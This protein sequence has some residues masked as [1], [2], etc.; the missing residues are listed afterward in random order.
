VSKVGHNTVYQLPIYDAPL[1]RN[2]LSD[3]ARASLD[4][5]IRAL[6]EELDGFDDKTRQSTMERRLNRFD[7]LRSR[8]ALFAGVLSFKADDL[9]KKLEQA[10]R[11]LR[12]MLGLEAPPALE[13]M[14]EELPVA[15]AAKEA[16]AWTPEEAIGF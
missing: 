3:V 11:D 12:V 6:Q 2:T 15:V 16:G 10:N 9:Q 4:D 1:V 14:D 8:V 13:E 5:E 7:E